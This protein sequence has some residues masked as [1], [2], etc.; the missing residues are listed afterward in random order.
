MIIKVGIVGISGY[1]G[2]T[3]LELLLNHPDVR[4]TYVSANNTTGKVDD[5]W[6]RLA[7]RTKLSCKKFQWV[8]R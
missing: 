2:G 4:V 8:K 5:I 3:L 6:P 7:V 1:S